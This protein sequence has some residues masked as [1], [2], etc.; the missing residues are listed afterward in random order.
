MVLNLGKKDLSV[1]VV[2]ALLACFIAGLYGIS[3]FKVSGG[4]LIPP[5][6]DTFIH[7][8]YAKRLSQGYFF[9]YT[10]G[11]GYSTGATSLLYPIILA[12]FFWLGISG[13]KILIPVFLLG[14]ISLILTA[15]G[16]YFLGKILDEPE[17]GFGAA[18]LTL[19]NGNLLWGFLSGMETGLYSMLVVWIVVL[20]SFFI[21]NSTIGSLRLGILLL[22]FA[23][24]TRPEGYL[25]AILTIIPFIF[26]Y[27][28]KKVGW[29]DFLL[30]ILALIP[31]TL[32]PIINKLLTGTYNSNGM[33]A[34]GLLFNPYYNIWDHLQK[35]GETFICIFSGYFENLM[36][37]K[38]FREFQGRLIYPYFPPLTI[39]F[40]VIG[41]SPKLFEEIKSHKLSTFSLG[42]IWFFLGI[43]SITLVEASFVHHQR[44][45]VPYLPL[46]LFF[47][48]YGV[49]IFS[50]IFSQKQIPHS[51]FL[52][53]LSSFL[54]KGLVLFFWIF[55]LPGIL[56][57]S[58]EFGENC[59]D[60]Y[61]QH[62]RMSWY[63]KDAIPKGEVVGVTDAGTIAYYGEHPIYDLVG[64][65]TN[66]QAEHFRNG[67]GSTFERLEKIPKEKRPKVIITY[68]YLF[69]EK[70]FLGEEIY[71]VS[72]L[73]NTITSGGYMS[74][75]RQNWD[76]VGSGDNC[77]SLTNPY[78]SPTVTKGGI[79]SSF[80][81]PP[82][83]ILKW[84]VVDSIDVADLE[85]EKEHS[86]I[87]WEDS[88][89]RS[90]LPYPYRGNLFVRGGY[91]SQKESRGNKTGDEVWD[92][93]RAITGGEKFV[94]N[95]KQ[96]KPIRLILRTENDYKTELDVSIDGVKVCGWKFQGKPQKLWYEEVLEIPAKFIS[97]DKIEV[98]INYIWDHLFDTSH[99]SF[100]YWA[101]QEVD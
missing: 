97:S 68:D 54:Y 41:F 72:L 11:A 93:G 100:Y 34:K 66:N 58:A 17:V 52:H 80:L 27:F 12:P 23:S 24:L 82:S 44:Y 88:E 90:Y 21:K 18:V 59:N 8:Q 51:S 35:I 26:W 32:Y 57:W 76:F 71:R 56:F 33:I 49:R 69:G 15:W 65:V 78:S 83:S 13:V 89:R 75:F 94:L 10:E 55:S 84:K 29:I 25:L 38:M 30:F 62:R 73:K 67:V 64:L 53:P 50:G 91:S 40:F 99:R 77:R 39:L 81:H 60:I 20:F 47:A 92:G 95:V 14:A 101:L 45:Y 70:N 61:N 48:I 5:L 19:L 3:M 79:Q 2:L 9:S 43:C 63:V 37:E 16:I 85:S 42:L 28:Q 86:Y 22:F 46:Y 96:A 74:V 7:L 4:H 98:K 6:D 31:G 1:I 87:F 36:G